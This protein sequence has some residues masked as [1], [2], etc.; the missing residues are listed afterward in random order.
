MHD[1]LHFKVNLFD[2]L[3]VLDSLVLNFED[4]SLKLLDK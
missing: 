3:V 2:I 4:L 1:E